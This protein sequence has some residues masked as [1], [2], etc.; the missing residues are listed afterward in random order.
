MILVFVA[1]MIRIAVPY[2][3]AAA[4]DFSPVVVGF[5]DGIET[6]TIEDAEMDFSKLGMQWRGYHDVGVSLFEYRGGV[7]SVGA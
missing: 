7:L 4:G 3:F 2:L 5:L 6:P 1:Q